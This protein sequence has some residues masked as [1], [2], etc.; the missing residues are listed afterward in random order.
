MRLFHEMQAVPQLLGKLRWFA[1]DMPELPIIA[2]GSLLEFTIEPF[3][4]EP[5]LLYWVREE[6][7][8]EVDY[9]I[10]HQNSIIPIEVK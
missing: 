1:E 4:I 10:Q 3:Y 7:G 5:Q 9:V 8:S 2:V 6:K